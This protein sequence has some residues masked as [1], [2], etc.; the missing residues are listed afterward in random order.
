MSGYGNDFCIISL[1]SIQKIIDQKEKQAWNNLM[2]VISHEL[3]NTLTPVNS[4]IY[5]LEYLTEQEL[6]LIHI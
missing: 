6:S 5:N 1:E 4:L 3:L 2:K